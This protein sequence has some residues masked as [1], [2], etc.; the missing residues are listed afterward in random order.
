MDEEINRLNELYLHILPKMKT[1]PKCLTYLCQ[2]E[3]YRMLKDWRYDDETAPY[4]EK[5]IEIDNIT[6][7]VVNKISKKI[8]TV[9]K[10]DRSVKKKEVWFYYRKFNGN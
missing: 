8:K 3:S 1:L 6:K 7:E 4:T 5:E 9:K 10:S 2:K